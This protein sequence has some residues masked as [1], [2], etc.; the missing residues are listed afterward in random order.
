M[1]L[2]DLEIAPRIGVHVARSKTKK[3]ADTPGPFVLEYFDSERQ[4]AALIR[5]DSQ[6]RI[7]I[8]G[9]MEAPSLISLRHPTVGRH[10]VS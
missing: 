3:H 8:R 2:Y 4:V 10:N 1:N 5:S 9:D 6:Q 7:L